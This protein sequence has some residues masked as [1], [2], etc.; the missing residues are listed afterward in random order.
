M[1]TTPQDAPT[2]PRRIAFLGIG[3]MGLPMAHR[4]LDA[5]HPLTVWN[6]TAAHAAPLVDA[7][8]ALAPTPAEAVRDAEVVI[9]ML[10]GPAAARAVADAMVPALRPD[11]YWIDT[12]TIGPDTTLELAAR[13]PR[14]VTLID[15]PVMGSVDRAATGDL[16]ILA[17]GDTAPV[18]DVLA[19]LGTVTAC[20]GPGTGA[21]LKLVLI[22]AVIGGVALVAESLALAEA[23]GLPRDLALRTLARGPLAGAVGR[24]TATGSHFP[25]AL[26]AKDVAL[27]TEVTELPLLEAVHRTLLEDPTLLTEDLAAV[28]R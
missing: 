9:T 19:R 28:A 2:D 4:L 17:G 14:G 12:S 27:A 24:A 21:A 11:A 8:A 13:I 10:A 7:G 26:A 15:A 22:N 18:A 16:L 1:D 25:V 6:R 5:G 3:S 23:L 20:G